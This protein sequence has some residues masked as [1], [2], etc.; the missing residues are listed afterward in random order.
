LFLLVNITSAK[1]VKANQAV[2][3]GLDWTSQADLRLELGYLLESI[4]S[5][6]K[7]RG[8]SLA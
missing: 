4:F 1:K 7:N 5:S 6:R 2:R 8:L 3:L